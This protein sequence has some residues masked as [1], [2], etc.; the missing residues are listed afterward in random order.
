MKPQLRVIDNQH[1]HPLDYA[2]RKVK[3]FQLD[4]EKGEKP[5]PV[6]NVH[7]DKGAKVLDVD[8]VVNSSLPNHARK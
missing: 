2:R 5:L 8:R 3:E 6:S 7:D 1:E 4:R